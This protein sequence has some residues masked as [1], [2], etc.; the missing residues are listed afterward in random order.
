MQP[1]SCQSCASHTHGTTQLEVPLVWTSGL[2]LGIATGLAWYGVRSDYLFALSA[3]AGGWFALADALRSAWKA[4]LDIEALMV[5]AAVGAAFLGKWFEAAFLLFLFSLG[6]ALEHRAMDRARQSVAALSKLRPS[7]ALRRKNPEEDWQEVES[8]LLEVGDILLVRPGERV[9]S[10]GIVRRG[11]SSLDQSAITGESMPVE[12]AP[13]DTV[14]AG[15]VNLQAALEVEVNRPVSDSVLARM[16]NLVAQAEA[17]RGPSQLF[18]RRVEQIFVPLAIL[19]GPILGGW[20]YW[21]GLP[22]GESV[23]RGISVLVA[24]SPCA[25]AISTPAAVLSALGR[26][27]RY[28][29]LVKGGV[30][31]ENLA[32]VEVIA[33][34]KTGTL[35]IGSPRLLATLPAPDSTAQEL[36]TTA[37]ALEQ[38]SS[39][40]LA[41][42]LL[43]EAQVQQWRL[44]EVRDSRAIAGRGLEGTLA[45]GRSVRLGSLA[46]FDDKAPEWVTEAV[47]EQNQLGRTT[48]VV[49]RE[50]TFL[51]VLGLADVPRAEAVATIQ[52]LRQCGLKKLVMLS[53]DNLSTAQAVARSL[54]LD[55]VHAPLLP[56]QKVS[57]V[58]TL[59]QDQRLA[60]VG[61]GIN[62]APALASASVGI[63]MGGAGSDVALETA[64]VVLMADRLDNLPVAI[65][66][67]R[68]AL[69]IIRQNL[70]IAIGVSILLIAASVFGWVNISQAVVLHEGSTVVVV[71]NGLRLL[72][73]QAQ[74]SSSESK[75]LRNA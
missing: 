18:A 62:D 56:E 26:A 47:A 1:H 48:I 68:Q 61:D 6:H 67:S 44:P 43:Q 60:M 75:P 70:C 22:L 66:L 33:F 36:L 73:F 50:G 16:L 3:L 49:Q 2:L 24:A 14:Y 58:K 38:E 5:L 28:G 19:G 17:Q 30:H 8:S 69:R 42:A 51:G 35:T 52:Q 55:E 40:P 34:D 11:I 45:D 15:T 10:D 59:A 27:A 64:D 46:L 57:W 20:L 37:A 23:L 65:E 9:A 21:R 71:L 32:K 39:H 41:R 53:G 25:L 12:R 72:W 4:K 74:S 54:G 7:R 29:I 31:L 63:A 13:D